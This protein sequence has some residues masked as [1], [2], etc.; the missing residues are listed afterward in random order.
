MNKTKN[1]LLYLLSVCSGWPIRTPTENPSQTILRRQPP[2]LHMKQIAIPGRYWHCSWTCLVGKVTKHL[3]WVKIRVNTYRYKWDLLPMGS[4]MISMGKNYATR[5]AIN[6]S[7]SHTYL[8]KKMDFATGPP[9][10]SNFFPFS[11]GNI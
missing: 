11:A 7:A 5:K 8:F 6:T 3:R 10:S 9:L 1:I 4:S 2:K